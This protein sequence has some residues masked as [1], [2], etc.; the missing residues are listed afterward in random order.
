M[1]SQSIWKDVIILILKLIWSLW[2]IYIQIHDN[3]GCTNR[4]M[5]A[6][7]IRRY[8]Y[9]N[10]KEVWYIHKKMPSQ[11]PHILSTYSGI[12][13]TESIWCNNAQPFKQKTAHFYG[14]SQ[15]NRYTALRTFKCLHKKCIDLSTIYCAHARRESYN[16]VRL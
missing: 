8:V 9:I 5:P 2:C 1:Q 12:W 15:I 3:T 4:E 6:L 16:S 10:H 7:T 13:I 11:T 14:G